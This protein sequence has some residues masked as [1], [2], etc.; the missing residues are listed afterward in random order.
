MQNARKEMTGSR[1]TAPASGPMETNSAQQQF[2]AEQLAAMSVT[3][4]A[5]HRE[6]LLGKAASDRNKGI[7]G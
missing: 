7:F 1:V 3:E 2:T 6:K 5:K 4:Y